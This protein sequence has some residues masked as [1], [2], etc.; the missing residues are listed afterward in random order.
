MANET[1]SEIT[2]GKAAQGSRVCAYPGCTRPTASGTGTGGR[3]PAYCEQEVLG[4]RH[5]RANAATA[6]R[7]LRE[8]GVSVEQAGSE[9]VTV[10]RAAA[11]DLLTRVETAIAE[12][13]SSMARL[14]EQMRAMGSPDVAAAQVTAATEVARADAAVARAA[15]DQAEAERVAAQARAVAAEQARDEAVSARQLAEAAIVDVQTL[16]AAA[17]LETETRVRELT[18][19]NAEAGRELAGVRAE[20][21]AVAATR[22][23]AT[24]GREQ[25]AERLITASVQLATT[26]AERDTAQASA[27]RVVAE[28]ARVTADRDTV[29]EQLAAATATRLGNSVPLVR[30]AVTVA[31]RS[32]PPDH[33]TTVALHQILETLLDAK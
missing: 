20:L 27:T 25:L 19:A 24:A 16:A 3:P 13:A 9:P 31:E 4:T 17:R 30:Q 23:E 10:A 29:R 32:L 26:T 12:Q 14:V 5:N 11:W 1:G 22:D 18:E 8:S 15:R 2:T 33:P 28:L 6:R 7:R 21:R